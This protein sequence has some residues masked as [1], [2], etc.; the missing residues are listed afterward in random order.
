MNRFYLYYTFLLFLLLGFS[1]QRPVTIG[2][3]ILLA[4]V[5]GVYE[6]STRVKLTSKSLL[7]VCMALML[8][9]PAVINF[10]FG[11]TSIFY[12]VTYPF[13]IICA[14]GLSYCK[15]SELVNLL[16]RF[17]WSFTLLLYF[18]AYARWELVDPFE[19]L[20]PG[21]STNGLPAYL[22]VVSVAYSIAI[23]LRYGRL[24]VVSGVAVLGIA[25]IGLGRSSM[26]ISALILL[27][28][29]LANA[30]IINERKMSGL[31]YLVFVAFVVVILGLY[32]G[33]TFDVVE[34]AIQQSKF[35]AGVVDEHRAIMIDDYINK[36]DAWSL[37]FGTDYSGTSIVQSYGGNPHNSFIRLHSFYGI[38]GLFVIL[39]P[40]YF[41]IA[42]RYPFKSKF[43]VLVLIS[44]VLI[45]S[46]TEPI[47]F[48]TPLDLFYWLYFFM[49]FRFGDGREI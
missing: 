30:L 49:F 10:N 29:F 38:V 36:I 26:I 11:L 45:R 9:L 31:A 12:L 47:L 1:W 6:I 5:C 20:I 35:S 32:S 14:F 24:P 3:S 22:I 40:V 39:S 43:I 8:I 27:F 2:L 23:Y 48:P 41:L 34:D 4:V 28:Y 17:F 42:S 13:I 44:L 19:G 33:V 21:T 7:L 25:M 37:L 15:L 18:V 16:S 46:G